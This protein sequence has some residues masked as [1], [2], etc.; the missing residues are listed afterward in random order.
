MRLINAKLLLAAAAL[1]T[2]CGA[3][4]LAQQPADEDAILRA[5]AQMQDGWNAKS[6]EAYARPFADEHDYVVINGM[7][8]PKM[9]RAENARAHQGILDGVYKEVDLSLGVA[10]TRFLA[11]DVCVA[12]VRGH[13]HAKGK[14]DDK[15]SEVVIT[16]VF[17]KK[18]GRWEII[19]FQ[20]TPVQTQP[21]R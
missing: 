18:A 2:L 6:G 20:N 13:S 16:L 11:P 14:P 1:A 21:G 19:A 8:L 9:T 5:V 12:H 17:Q 10:K 15:R 7:F 4:A 3:P